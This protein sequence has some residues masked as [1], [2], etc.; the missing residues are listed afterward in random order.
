[1]K[2][3]VMK[4]VGVDVSKD[5]IDVHDPELGHARYV[6][7]TAGF[8][9]FIK[10]LNNSCHVV[11]EATGSYS[12]LLA[13]YLYERGIRVSIVNPLVIKRYIQM[14]L[15]W[16]KTDKADAKMI[17]EYAGNQP[18]QCWEPD[19]AYV[20]D[21]KDLCNTA[22]LY[23]KYRTGLKNK[24]HALKAKGKTSG[25]EVR[26][27][28][29][30]IKQLSAQIKQLEAKAEALM[31]EHEAELMTLLTS[32]PGIGRKTART[33]ILVTGA[34]SQFE[35]AKQVCAYLGLAPTQ[36]RSGTSIRGRS[37][38]SKAGNKNLRNLLY[39]CSCQ[40]SRRNPQCTAL[41]NRLL[42]KGKPKNLALTAVSHKLVN[43]AFAIAKSRMPYD[44]KFRSTL[45]AA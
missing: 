14:K 35:N 44:P 1:M 17:A 30:T 45:A 3:E 22:E 39:L 23:I 42:A 12:Q 6:N 41:Y 13:L 8:K 7:G 43:Q 16:N 21:C 9:K 24:L 15:R 38:I 27:M 4:F 36:R 2:R 11:M 18:L 5:Y 31:M 10:T 19:P 33:M 25:D 20:E 32:I 28:R 37:Y 29:N 26:S 40:A 34:M